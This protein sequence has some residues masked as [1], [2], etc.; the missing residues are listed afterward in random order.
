MLK[1]TIE[2]VS[3]VTGRTS[4]IGRMFIANDGEASKVNPKLGDYTVAVCKRGTSA[5]PAPIDELGPCSVRSGTVR[6]YPRHEHTV[7]RLVTQALHVAFPEEVLPA[8]RK[9]KD[10]PALDATV[11]RGLQ[12][13]RHYLDAAQ[14]NGT[15]MADVVA[16]HEWLDAANLGVEI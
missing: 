14:H 10:Y 7:W 16:A 9:A 1:V 15:T 13:L 12:S 11:M 2:L 3:A 5:V 4:E 6:D 8:K